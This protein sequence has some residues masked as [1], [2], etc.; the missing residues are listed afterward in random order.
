MEQFDPITGLNVA[1][2]D[3]DWK[4]VGIWTSPARRKTPIPT[5]ST[6]PAPTTCWVPIERRYT[7]RCYAPA[8]AKVTV[9]GDSPEP[10]FDPA[11]YYKDFDFASITLDEEGT[12]YIYN[13]K[14]VRFM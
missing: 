6:R 2:Y 3:A 12:Q 5:H 14:R 8:T 10:V 1:V 9:T 11:E 7:G 13:I 4:Y